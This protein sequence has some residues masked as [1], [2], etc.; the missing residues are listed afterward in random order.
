MFRLCSPDLFNHACP[1]KE[2]Y[3]VIVDGAGRKWKVPAQHILQAA[4]SLTV[5]PG[6]D[7]GMGCGRRRNEAIA[8][9]LEI[10][11]KVKQS[12]IGRTTVDRCH[13]V[14]RFRW[15]SSIHA[16]PPSCIFR[17][18]ERRVGKESG[19]TCRS[20]WSPYH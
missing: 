9:L 14:R 4:R 1:K 8:R 17:S 16:S 5:R 10:I 20:R 12:C 15:R 6:D 13:A 3:G 7:T 11:E 2:A 18:E 19:S